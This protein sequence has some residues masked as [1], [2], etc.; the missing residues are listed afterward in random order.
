MCTLHYTY[1]QSFKGFGK[2]LYFYSESA[3]DAINCKS[4]SKYIYNV[5]NS[6]VKRLIACEIKQICLH[7]ICVY[8]VYVYYV[9][10]YKYKH[11]HV[12]VQ[13]I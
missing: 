12:Y 8:T 3:I 4:N 11:M 2:K 7:N 5:T 10:I 9:Y 1:I 13:Y 6:A